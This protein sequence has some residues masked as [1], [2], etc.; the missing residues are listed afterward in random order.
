M[1]LNT[2]AYDGQIRRF[3]YQFIRIMS[4]FQVEFGKDRD[5]N[6]SLQ[7]VPVFYGDPSRQVSQILRGNTENALPSVPAMA[8]YISSMDYD[9]A[10]VQEPYHVSKLN[11]RER[12]YEHSVTPGEPGTWG[13]A[14]GNAFTVERLMPV[15]Y[16]LTL[17][18]DIWTSNTEQKLQLLEQMLPLFNPALEIQSTDNYIDWTSLSAI[19]L[20]NHVWSSRT[21]PGSSIDDAMDI[22]TLTFELPIWLSLPAKVK[23]L[24]VIHKIIASI[25]DANGDLLNDLVDLPS[26]TLLSQRIITPLQ[27]GVIYLNNT[28][29]LFR[30]TDKVTNNFDTVDVDGTQSYHWLTLVNMYGKTLVNGVSEIRLDQP[31]GST[32]VGTVSYHPTDARL[33]I[34][35][36]ILDTTPGNTLAAVDAIIDPF[37]MPVDATFLTPTVGTRYLILNDIGSESNTTGAI[38][39][40][41]TDDSDLIA[42]ANDIIEYDGNKWFVSFA[43]AAETDVK[44]VTNIRSGTQYKWISSEQAWSKSIEGAYQAGEWTMVLTA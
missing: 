43:A 9:R 19:F 4:N 6:T 8:C 41:G 35:N 34:F 18:V 1:S 37:S 23:Q 12:D 10:R 13:N 40:H 30:P 31:N 44:Y 42:K 2:F 21:V 15:P 11:I 33:L 17:K 20:T 3:L 25:Y 16:K 28:L 32:V 26:M 22:A 14:Q 24:G 36:P 5:G 29:E 38:A 27:Y 39:W 7:Q